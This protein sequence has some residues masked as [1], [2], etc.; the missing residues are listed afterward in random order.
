MEWP[1]QIRNTVPPLRPSHQPRHQPRHRPS[2]QPRH[3]QT[4]RVHTAFSQPSA[5]K[6]T[7]V[8]PAGSVTMATEADCRSAATAL[9][10]NNFYVYSWHNFPKGCFQSEGAMY[11]NTNTRGGSHPFARPICGGA[12]GNRCKNKPCSCSA[13]RWNNN[14][15]S[16]GMTFNQ[17]TDAGA[18]SCQ[19]H[20]RAYNPSRYPQ[21]GMI[22]YCTEGP[23][24]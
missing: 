13:I 11:W 9:G 1:T 20:S 4:H 2:I 15:E 24:V 6:N 12:N 10:N 23:Y 22:Y 18:A 14:G 17:R 3:Q 7:N 19:S 16:G 5:Q 8:C 21:H